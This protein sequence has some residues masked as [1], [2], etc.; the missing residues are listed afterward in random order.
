MSVFVDD[1]F[2]EGDWGRWTGGGHMQADTADELHAM[3]ERLGLRRAWF[4]SKP[5]RPWHDHYDLT[6]QRRERAIELGAI[7]VGR[8]EAV[9]RNA[10]RRAAYREAVPE[11]GDGPASGAS[12]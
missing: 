7:P 11:S 3:A 8:R 4:Q 9:R 2:A 6:R 12:R 10:A 1:A 5:A